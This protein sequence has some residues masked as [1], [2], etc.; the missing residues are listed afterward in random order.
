MPVEIRQL[1]IRSTI[2]SPCRD[3]GAGD[4]HDPAGND[5]DSSPGT[6]G[7]TWAAVQESLRRTRE[8]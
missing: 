6:H 5:S 8:R 2:A 4:E 1:N 3:C 7:T